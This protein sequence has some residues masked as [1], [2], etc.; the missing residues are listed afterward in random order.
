MDIRQN[1]LWLSIPIGTYFRTEVRVSVWFL[2]LGVI[3]CANLGLQLGCIVT[4]IVFASIVLHEFGH[5]WAVRKTGGYGH[6]I[7]I[8]PLGGLAFVNPAP[9]FFSEF[10]TVAAGPIVHF[11][12]CLLLVPFLFNEHLLLESSTLLTLPPLDLHGHPMQSLMQLV[13]S[14]NLHLMLLNLLPIHPLDGG[15]MTYHVAKLKWDRHTAKMG[16]LWTGMIL[17]LVLM[18]TGVILKSTDLVFLGSILMLLS[19]YEHLT[20]QVNR[21]LEDSFMGYDFSQGYTSLEHRDDREARQPGFL[22]RW[23]IERALKKQE[24]ELQQKI[25]TEQRVDELLD[26]VHQHGMSS[27]TDS[28]RR[29]LQRASGRYRSHGKE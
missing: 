8:W 29:F 12:I 5:I 27:L 6:E 9:T 10:W 25:E 4:G 17:S 1:P 16:T 15:Q 2:M 11:L 7:L 24:K 21:P 14:I 18:V 19:T 13:Y 23:R 20:A 22:E 28:E 3:F 26:K